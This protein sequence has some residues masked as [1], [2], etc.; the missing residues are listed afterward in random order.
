MYQ[1]PK[2]SLVTVVF[3]AEATLQKTLDSVRRQTYKP[4]EYILIDGGSTDNTLDIIKS[5]TDIIT[6]FVSEK[7]NGISD[8]FNKGIQICNGDLIGL[9]NADDWYEDNSL[10][11]VAKVWKPNSVIYGDMQTWECKNKGYVYHANHHL[12]MKD[13]SICH[14][15]TFISKSV[16]EKLGL[17]NEDFRLAMDYEFL[18]RCVKAEIVFLRVDTVLTH[19]LLEG[20]SIKHWKKARF[21]VK[22]AQ[23]LHFPENKVHNQIEYSKVIIRKSISNWLDSFGLNFITKFYRKNITSNKKSV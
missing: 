8:A 7:D 19:M 22:K 15:S 10:S 17:Y 14:P 23:N 13:M 9:L 11:Q 20:A 18:L 2:I 16:Y 3:N 1:F 6:H 4:F 5:N 12:L 21:E